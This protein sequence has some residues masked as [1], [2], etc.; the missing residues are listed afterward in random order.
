MKE[1]KYFVTTV[2]L[3]IT[4]LILIFLIYKE[5]EKNTLPKNRAIEQSFLYNF[6]FPGVLHES[7]KPNESSSPYWWLDSG[8]E[9]IIENGIGKTM[10]GLSDKSNKWYK[11]YLKENPTDTDQ[12]LHPQNIFRLISKNEW[13]NFSQ[14]IY[15]YINGDNLS[16]SPNRNESNGL[17]LFSR[18]V[19]SNNLYYAGIRVDGTAVIK[20]KIN[21][22]YFTLSQKAIIAGS[23][24]DRGLNPN[25]LP[26]NTWIGVKMETYNDKFGRVNI[27]IYVDLEN[28]GN[29]KYTTE[30]IDEGINS[31]PIISNIAPAGIRTDFMDVYFSDYLAKNIK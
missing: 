11:E 24:Y 17:F 22:V 13:K 21:S 1:K 18:Y 20:K 27:R 9:L 6:D 23:A 4:V 31:G 10:Q 28:S 26:K 7:G 3:L 25:L 16:S 5:F 19:D 2:F 15:F 30:A 8:G 29:W 14:Q 12:G